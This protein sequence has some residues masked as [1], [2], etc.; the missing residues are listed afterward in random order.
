MMVVPERNM[1]NHA[2]L[3]IASSVG[4]GRKPLSEQS[5]LMQPLV[6]WRKFRW[7]AEPL[8]FRQYTT[9]KGSA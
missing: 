4:Q 6:A 1:A 7:Q 8:F 2:T 3:R 9:I 5:R